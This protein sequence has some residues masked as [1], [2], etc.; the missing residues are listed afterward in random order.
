MY[1]AVCGVRYLH[2]ANILHRDLKPA[3]M[4]INADCSLKICDFGL[5]RSYR[6]LNIT[7]SQEF[8]DIPEEDVKTVEVG[9]VQVRRLR[10][11]ARRH[12]NRK[13][14]KHVVTRWYRAPEIILME[15]DYDKSLDVWSLG[16]IFAELLMMI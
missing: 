11:G 15:Q 3:N 14:T 6:L 10:S 12:S 7:D 5:S 9:G 16:C 13:M 1:Q 4:L 8:P 2:S